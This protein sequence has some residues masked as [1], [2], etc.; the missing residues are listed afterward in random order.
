[1]FTGDMITA[2][3]AAEMGM[4]NSVT[5]DSELMERVMKLAERLAQSPTA[6]IAHMKRLLEASAMNDYGSQLDKER[7]AQIE[8]GRTKDFV[9]GVS[10]F[11]E[12]R[13]PRFVGS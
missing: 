7:E 13:P 12:K 4:I 11:L 8:A 9:E 2:Q 5:P 1:M 6:A 3:R 10:A